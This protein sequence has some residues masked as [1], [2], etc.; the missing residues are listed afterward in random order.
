MILGPCIG[1]LLQTREIVAKNSSDGF[2]TYVSF[3]LLTANLIR[4]YWWYCE[5]FS[6][7][8]LIA[9]IF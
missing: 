8:I 7:V 5:R 1:I 4:L 6:T 3:I 2:S 9:A